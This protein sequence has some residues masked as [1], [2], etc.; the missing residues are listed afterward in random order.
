MTFNRE[1]YG[2]DYTDP[3]WYDAVIDTT[4]K[5]A[6]EALFFMSDHIKTFDPLWKILHS[7]T[8]NCN[9]T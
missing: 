3:A 2:A 8:L 7:S 5:T 9:K 1:L 4:G 6:E